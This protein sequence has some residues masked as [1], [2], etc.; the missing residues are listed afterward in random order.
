MGAIEAA[1]SA[2]KSESP[3][4]PAA[5]ADKEGFSQESHRAM[6]KMH[7]AMEAHKSTEDADA[8]FAKMMALHHKGAVEMSQIYLKYQK[9]SKLKTMAEKMIADQQ[10]EIK[11]LELMAVRES[12]QIK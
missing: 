10:K 3:S 11:Q 6:M 4:I 2:E 7:T 1:N 5:H 8:D 9:N 12:K